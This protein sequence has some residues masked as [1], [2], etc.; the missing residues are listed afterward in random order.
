MSVLPG[1]DIKIARTNIY[2][3]RS[4]KSAKVEKCAFIEILMGV[5]YGSIVRVCHC[6]VCGNEYVRAMTGVAENR[7]Y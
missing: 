3:S 6:P 4:L 7:P 2:F 1:P 5:C